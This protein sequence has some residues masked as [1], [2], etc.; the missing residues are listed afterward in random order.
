M[1]LGRCY[2]VTRTGTR[3]LVIVFGPKGANVRLLS[4]GTQQDGS[5]DFEKSSL[6]EE[7]SDLRESSRSLLQPSNQSLVV[8]LLAHLSISGYK[9]GVVILDGLNERASDRAL[10]RVTPAS[11]DK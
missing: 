4:G 7:S 1:M 2:Q 11:C 10:G 8:C 9:T 5:L 6:V 3:L